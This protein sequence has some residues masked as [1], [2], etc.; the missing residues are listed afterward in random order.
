M[1]EIISELISE[2]HQS[3]PVNSLERDYDIPFNSGKI[4]TLIGPRRSGK[5]FLFF[6]LIKKLLKKGVEKR[7]IIYLNFEDERLDSETGKPDEILQ[8]YR[9]IYPDKKLNNC[10]FFL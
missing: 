9:E 4:I 8:A 5:S 2:F 7:Q 10:Y 1:K 3:E 6:N